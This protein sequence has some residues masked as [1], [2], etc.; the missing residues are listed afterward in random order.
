M[1]VVNFYVTQGTIFFLDKQAS[2][3]IIQQTA[4]TTKAK[5]GDQ[6]NHTPLLKTGPL[7]GQLN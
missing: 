7:E 3:H 2:V 6:S 4:L 1:D 5:E